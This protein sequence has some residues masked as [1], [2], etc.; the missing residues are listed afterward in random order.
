MALL[1][2]S[3]DL[4]KLEDSTFVLAVGMGLCVSYI[5]VY[6]YTNITLCPNSYLRFTDKPPWFSCNFF[7]GSKNRSLCL[8]VR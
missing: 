3:K 5:H 8:L 7:K 1:F 4:S 2:K 6:V